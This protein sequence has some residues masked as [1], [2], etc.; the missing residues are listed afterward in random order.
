MQR[1]RNKAGRSARHAG[2]PDVE[3]LYSA[4]PRERGDREKIPHVNQHVVQLG[5][6]RALMT[7][8]LLKGVAAS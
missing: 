6:K 5:T 2:I 7:R 1:E 8:N 3:N 4:R